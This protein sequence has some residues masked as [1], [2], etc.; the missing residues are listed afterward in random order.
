MYIEREQETNHEEASSA[1]T[2]VVAQPPDLA[3]IMAA[4]SQLTLE[5][6]VSNSRLEG[7][8]DQLAVEV[9]AVSTRI[10]TMEASTDT[11]FQEIE[12]RLSNLNGQRLAAVGP[13]GPSGPASFYSPRLP[14]APPARGPPPSQAGG[15]A[16]AY[17]AT[18]LWVKHI[19]FGITTCLQKLNGEAMISELPQH[20][21]NGTMVSP[22]Y[23][24]T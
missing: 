6:R 18:V 4:I 5:V 13:P 17:N 15:Q 3:A 23:F 24:G 22:K 19:P 7:R 16:A 2:P 11:R 10:N 14:S 20:I 9:V 21:A 8:I 1:R 12:A